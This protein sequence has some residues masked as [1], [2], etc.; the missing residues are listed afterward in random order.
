MNFKPLAF[1]QHCYGPGQD[2]DQQANRFYAYS[3]VGRLAAL[4]AARELEQFST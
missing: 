3:V 4:A 2:Q 1:A